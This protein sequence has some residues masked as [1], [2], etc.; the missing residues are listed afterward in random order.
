MSVRNDTMNGSAMTLTQ[1][2]AWEKY[3]LSLPL[4]YQDV[5]LFP[6][7]ARLFGNVYG[8]DA[9]IFCL[10]TAE[11]Q[12]CN[13]YLLRPVHT[14]PFYSRMKDPA[15]LFDII[16]PEYSGPVIAGKSR[17]GQDAANVF[18][19]EWSAFCAHQGYI[20]EFGR[21]H[22]YYIEEEQIRMILGARK[23]RQ[24]VTLDLTQPEKSLWKGFSK[25]NRSSIKKALREGVT[26]K[27]I[28][29]DTDA[30]KAFYQ[31]YVKT[32][33]RAEARAFYFF[34][35]S[36]FR[37][38][39]LFLPSQSSLFAAYY[40]GQII[41]ASIFLHHGLYMH[42]YF[43]GSDE[44]F[45]HVCPNNLMVHEALRWGKAQGYQRCNLGGGYHANGNDTL[46]S[47]KASFSASRADFYTYRRVYDQTRY[48]AVCQ[49]YFDYHAV[50]EEK[51]LSSGSF[52][53]IYREP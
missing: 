25:G 52:F 18:F 3:I 38:L 12:A 16:T 26:V 30:I 35:E 9:G 50:P 40:Q 44:R 21:M 43:S 20:A 19:R 23:N 37:D 28:E 36:F 32:M 4:K 15:Q 11:S 39:F 51:R 17:T 41:A 42:Y 45:L 6:G 33:K 8:A 27:R 34:S 7:Y 53:P 49:A 31:V 13:A 46:F 5:F 2:D 10:S 24:I 48:D 1:A 29:P 22:P 47:F 14:L